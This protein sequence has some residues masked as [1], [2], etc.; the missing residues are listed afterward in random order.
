MAPPPS[1]KRFDKFRAAA[2]SNPNRN[3]GFGE[4]ERRRLRDRDRFFLDGDL[5]RLLFRDRDL[6]FFRSRDR[7]RFFF[8]DRDRDL[9]EDEDLD[10][11]LEEDLLF[12]FLPF[13]FAFRDADCDASFVLGFF[14]LSFV[15]ETDRDLDL[16][17]FFPFSF[18]SNLDLDLDA[19]HFFFFCSF[20]AWPLEDSELDSLFS[21]SPGFFCFS[22]LRSLPW[23]WAFEIT[24]EADRD[25]AEELT[26][27]VRSS[28]SFTIMQF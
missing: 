1:G 7:D 16:S 21:A 26:S 2:W 27:G 9:L 23:S 11:F 15:D 5:D 25:A 28:S 10:L 12:F 8:L 4:L 14:F 22:F 6:S 13:F 24:G 18:L 17:A 19:E 20:F 3:C